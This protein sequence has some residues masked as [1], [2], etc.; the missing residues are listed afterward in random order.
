MAFAGYPTIVSFDEASYIWKVSQQGAMDQEHEDSMVHLTGSTPSPDLNTEFRSMA[1]IVSSTS[2]PFYSLSTTPD[3]AP[4]FVPPAN[5][6]ASVSWMPTEDIAPSFDAYG[7]TYDDGTLYR[8]TY[9]P[10]ETD[11]VNQWDIF[12]L[13][14]GVPPGS[15][16]DSFR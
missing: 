10:A 9:V 6:Q 15:P 11:A 16:Q 5:L 8:G 3:P 1:R 2:S 13:D 12:L 7:N 4:N 14:T